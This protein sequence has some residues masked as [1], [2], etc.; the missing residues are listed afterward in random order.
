MLDRAKALVRSKLVILDILEGTIKELRVFRAT[1]T[2][3]CSKYIDNKYATIGSVEHR[4]LSVDLSFI[5][6]HSCLELPELSRSLA[7]AVKMLIQF[8]R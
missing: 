6:I 3:V 1:S 7:P 5:S 4:S 2:S 8:L